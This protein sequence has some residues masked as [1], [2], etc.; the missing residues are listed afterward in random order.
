[1]Q[2][3]IN[4][5]TENVNESVLLTDLIQQRGVESQEMVSI[6]LNGEILEQDEVDAIVLKEND[7][8]EFLYFMGGGAGR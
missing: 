6:E 3:K 5:K 2:L 7:E 4:G 1:M 8:V